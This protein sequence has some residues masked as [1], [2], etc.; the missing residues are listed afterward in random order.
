MTPTSL[1][2]AICCL[3]ATKKGKLEI[4]LIYFLA[5]AD[6]PICLVGRDAYAL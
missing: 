5:Q 6:H 3:A 1:V 2:E 4:Q